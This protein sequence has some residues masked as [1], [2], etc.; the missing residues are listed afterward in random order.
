MRK[1][2]GNPFLMWANLA[3]KAGEMML[4]SAQVIGH[5]TGRMAAAGAIPN[6]RDRREFALM[7]QEKVDA[8]AESAQAM[9][10]QIVRMNMQ[11]GTRIFQ[12]MLTGATD[13]MALA[14][15][16]NASQSVARQAKLMRTMTRSADTATRYSNAAVR[17]AQ[18]GLKPIH[19]RATANAKR[20]GKG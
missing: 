6:E 16:S 20:L 8:A 7:G 5:R 10:T 1:P 17:L 2:T 19:S 4:A 9:T 18:Q 13:L 15:S 14:A 3:F 12:Q 11:L